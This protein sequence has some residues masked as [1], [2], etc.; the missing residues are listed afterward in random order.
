M[1]LPP[2]LQQTLDDLDKQLHEKGTF[3]DTLAMIETK[4]GVKRLNIVLGAVGLQVILN[5]IKGN[6]R[7]LLVNHKENANMHNTLLRIVISRGELC[8]T[9]IRSISNDHFVRNQGE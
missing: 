1:S 9:R 4:T 5:S 7:V 2:Q 3:T 8:I 6:E